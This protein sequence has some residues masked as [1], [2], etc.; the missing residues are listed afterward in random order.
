M[1]ELAFNG[2]M[3]SREMRELTWEQIDFDKGLLTVGRS[4]T[5]AGEG[6]MVPLNGSLLKAL[7]E[8]GEWYKSRFGELRPNWYLFPGRLGKPKS[9]EPRPYDPTRPI[10]TL[11]SSW[12]NVKI[13]AGVEGRMHDAR[14]TLITEMGERGVGEETIMSIVGHVSR[15]MLTHYSHIR[16]EAKRRA[17]EA[18][19]GAAT[20]KTTPS[21]RSGS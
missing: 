10:T 11:K 17:V 4:K 12:K 6:R 8:H 14:H 7:K 20:D 16:M 9:G 3:R 15:R 18:I 13:A 19:D 5:A 1:L 21:D 2:G